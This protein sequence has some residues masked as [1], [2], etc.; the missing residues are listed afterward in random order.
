MTKDSSTPMV[1]VHEV[2]RV[3]GVS[4]ATV[5]RFLNGTARV[6]EDKRRAIE[7]VIERLNYKPNVLARN[8]KTGS[9]RTVGV[10]TQSLVSGYFA[11]ALAGVDDALQGTGYAP[12]IVSGHWHADEEAERIELLIARRV[13]GLVILSGNLKDAQILKLSQRV[14]IVA[15]GRRLEGT[16]AYGFC[17]DN[18]RGACD[19]VEHLLAHGHRDIAFITG[20]SDHADALARLAGYRDTLARHGILEQ[21]QLVLPADFDESSGLAAVE[22]LLA[23]GQRFSAIFAANDLSAY[24]ARLAL[25]RRDIRVPDDVSV[26]GF[27]DLHSS[28]YTTPPL[29]TVRQPLFDVGRCLGRAILAMIGGEKMARE[30]PELSLVVRESVRRVA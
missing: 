14:P 13:D 7:G 17:L 29:T 21:P 18:Y 15:F 30:M 5:S 10:L 26:V 8:L 4:A 12:L 19:A 22:R 3:A 23:S 1:T 16:R 24:G 6:S 9:S 20:P 27:D 25:Y 28:M 11:D 2:A